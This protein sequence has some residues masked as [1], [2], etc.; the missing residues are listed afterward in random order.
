MIHARLTTAAS[1]I[2]AASAFLG[3]C[4][5]K[6]GPVEEYLRVGGGDAACSQDTQTGKVRLAVA[7]RQVKSAD[8]LDRQAVMLARGRVMSPS[9]RWY[10]EASPCR[11]AEQA[12]VRAVNCTPGLAAIWPVR[13]STEAPLSMAVTLTAFEVQ[14][15]PTVMNA[16]MDCQIWDGSGTK[17]LAART[18]SAQVPAQA[19]DAQAIAEAGSKALSGLSGEAAQWV[20]SLSMPGVLGAPGK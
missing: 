11:L 16:A 12:L 6:P 5:G 7:L 4:L 8:A 17:L 13:S 15:Q 20:A 2:L 19:L 10:W 3:G 9:L 1:L 14:E 18:F